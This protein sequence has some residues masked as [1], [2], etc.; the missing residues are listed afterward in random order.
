MTMNHTNCLEAVFYQKISK[1][2]WTQE[3]NT[4]KILVTQVDASANNLSLIF[5][6]D[7]YVWIFRLL[8]N[9]GL[10]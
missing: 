9:I 2:L 3:N 1:D 4:N 7:V 6:N 10:C 5:S 8:A